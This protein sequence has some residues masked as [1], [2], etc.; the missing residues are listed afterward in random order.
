MKIETKYSIGDVVYH[1]RNRTVPVRTTCPDCNGTKLWTIT[2]P[3]GETVETACPTCETLYCSTGY[4]ERRERTPFV[5]TLT[6]GSVRFDSHDSG[7]DREPASYMCRETGVGS[8]SIWYESQLR[9][10]REEAEIDAVASIAI[11]E[12]QVADFNAAYEKEKLKKAARRAKRAA[13]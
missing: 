13:K 3:S 8:G 5:E 11:S 7:A 2:K 10:T 1:G 4:I 6:I 9:A 12:K